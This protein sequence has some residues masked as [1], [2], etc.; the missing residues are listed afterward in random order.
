M[1]DR[2]ST[3]V[4]G[5]SLQRVS[6]SQLSKDFS[7]QKYD[8]CVTDYLRTI[9]IFLFQPAEKASFFNDFPLSIK[10]SMTGKDVCSINVESISNQRRRLELAKA[11]VNFRSAIYVAIWVI[12]FIV[13]LVFLTRS[14]GPTY[15]YLEYTIS[16]VVIAGCGFNVFYYWRQHV[17]QKRRWQAY[18]DTAA[19]PVAGENL[20]LYYDTP[21]AQTCITLDSSEVLRNRL[22]EL[23][24]I[25]DKAADEIIKASSTVLGV[26]IEIGTENNP[27]NDSS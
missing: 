3:R 27:N 4:R 13:A 18:Y 5:A 25:K 11:E 6:S 15:H 22:T 1:I 19:T 16:I 10:I 9:V 12:M 20:N 17:K 2:F 14:S 24:D 21:L 23:K 8:S 26:S 7:C